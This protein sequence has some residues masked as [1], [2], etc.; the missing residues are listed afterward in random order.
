MFFFP[1]IIGPVVAARLLLLLLKTSF[2]PAFKAFVMTTELEPNGEEESRVSDAEILG[3]VV[4]FPAAIVEVL[5]LYDAVLLVLLILSGQC[6]DEV[7][8]AKIVE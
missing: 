4:E 1:P 8:A 2:V 7:V 5:S 3:G 6:R